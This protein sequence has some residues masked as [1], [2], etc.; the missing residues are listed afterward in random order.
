VPPSKGAM[1][2]AV[3]GISERVGGFRGSHARVEKKMPRELAPSLLDQVSMR[4][5]FLL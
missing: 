4:R 5:T 3:F 1:E 2:H